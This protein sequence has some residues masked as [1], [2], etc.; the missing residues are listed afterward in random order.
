MRKIVSFTHATFDGYIEPSEWSFS[1]RW[2]A[3]SRRSPP[4]C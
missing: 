1:R 4:P 3:R 2:K